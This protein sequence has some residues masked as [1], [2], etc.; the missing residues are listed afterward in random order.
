MSI[1]ADLAPLLTG[2]VGGGLLRIGTS[3][4]GYFQEKQTH[5]NEMERL[6]FEADNTIKLQDNTAKNGLTALAAQTEATV[7]SRQMDA[8]VEAI[9]LQGQLTGNKFIDGLNMLVRPVAFY[10]WQTMYTAVKA[11]VVTALWHSVGLQNAIIQA[12]TPWDESVFGSVIGFF[13][14]D[15]VISKGKHK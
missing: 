4:L 14:V 15:R 2:G 13:F 8:Y 12:W 11:C 3:V 5:A 1:I 7:T 6:R 9:K 10:W